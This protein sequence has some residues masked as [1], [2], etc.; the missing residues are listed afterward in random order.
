M[1]GYLSGQSFPESGGG[2]FDILG[3]GRGVGFWSF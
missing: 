1:N 3:I 2:R